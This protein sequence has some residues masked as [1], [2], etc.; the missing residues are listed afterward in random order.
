MESERKLKEKKTRKMDLTCKEN[1][2]NMVIEEKKKKKEMEDVMDVEVS[3]SKKK[4]KKSEKKIL[5]LDENPLN[6]VQNDQSFEENGYGD[7]AGGGFHYKN[8]NELESYYT[9]LEGSDLC[10]RKSNESV[11]Y[12]IDPN[13]PGFDHSNPP[14]G[15]YVGP[16]HMDVFINLS[17][18]GARIR[19]AATLNLVKDLQEI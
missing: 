5:Y 16:V 2:G 4:K 12:F 9:N 14:H 11:I 13:E 17:S 15:K 10:I 1:G 7:S 8:P 3:M 19:A 6:A 18:I